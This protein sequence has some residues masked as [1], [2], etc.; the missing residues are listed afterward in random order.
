MKVIQPAAPLRQEVVR[1]VRQEILDGALPPGDRLRE[2]DLCA[3]YGVSRT[4]VREALRQLESESLITL[5]PN[6]GPIVTVLTSDDI[7][8]L[9]EVRATLE[10]L[11]GEL[12][13]RCATD[14]EAAQ[15]VEH[16]AEMDTTYLH[17]DLASRGESKERFYTLLLAG[18][19]NPVLGSTLQGVHS[20]IAIFRHYA[21]VDDQRVALSMDELRRIVHWAAVE[22]HP[23]RARKACKD[24]IRR[25]SRLAVLEYERRHSVSQ[26]A[27]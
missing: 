24:H 6:R 11:A 13:A 27:I 17:G 25:A 23:A 10:G 1:R 16:L 19:H 3:R 12:F 20:R 5:L 14:A 21:F 7:A 9:Y 8:A 22:R 4:V 18:G 26:L 15:L 2:N